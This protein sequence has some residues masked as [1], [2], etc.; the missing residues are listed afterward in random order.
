SARAILSI[1]PFNLVL[2]A[3]IVASGLV[4]PAWN[5]TPLAGAALA[6][7]ATTASRRERGFSIN[8]S[9]FAERHGLVALCALVE[10]VVSI[11]TGAAGQ[12]LQPSLLVAMG[13]GIALAACVWWT[14]FDA[15]D[16]R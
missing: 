2:A 15:D 3:L 1:L 5:W 9:H 13:L 10:S 14:Y 11:G 4:S 7:V 6:I 8:P 12:P 16:T